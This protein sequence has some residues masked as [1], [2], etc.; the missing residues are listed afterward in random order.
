MCSNSESSQGICMISRVVI[1]V[2]RRVVYHFFFIIAF[3]N[4]ISLLLTGALKYLGNVW[5]FVIIFHCVSIPIVQTHV[6]CFDGDANTIKQ[7]IHCIGEPIII[8]PH[9]YVIVTIITEFFTQD[10]SE[11]IYCFGLFLLF[12]RIINKSTVK[13][14]MI[15]I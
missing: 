7:F 10:L 11:I 1:V 4:R 3:E 15:N 12:I 8:L 5:I 9:Y 13:F 2:Y 14:L 6:Y